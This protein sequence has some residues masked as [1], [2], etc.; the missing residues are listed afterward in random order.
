MKVE[1]IDHMGSDLSVVNAARV[2]FDKESLYYKDDVA[3][4]GDRPH[5]V[6]K[7]IDA[8]AKLIKYLAEH[9]HWSPFAHATVSMRWK[10]PIFVARQ[11]VKHQV[12]LSW[13]E[14]SRRY[15]KTEPELYWPE[16]WRRAAEN[17]KQG[18]SDVVLEEPKVS[19]V[20]LYCSASL[21]IGRKKYC[22][23]NHQAQHS[24]KKRPFSTKFT[25]WRATAKEQKIPFTIS[26]D[27]LD[28]PKTCPY[29]GIE[30]AYSS[31][32]K[33]DNTASLD[34]IKPEL[35]Y[36]PGNVQ[37]ISLLANR[38]KSDAN[39]E[40]LL[41]F[42]KSVLLLH[43]GIA[44]SE[45]N[46]V[47]TVA[48]KS[49]ELYNQLIAAGYCPEQARIVLPQAMETEWIWTGSLYAWAR[50]YNQR[51]DPHAQQETRQLVLTLDEIC[52]K[53]YPVSWKALTQS[54]ELQNA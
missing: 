49:I 2:S 14:V 27:D 23:D 51:T 26:E 40:Q 12:G 5:F 19:G 6:P 3:L 48:E 31:N 36:V 30:L 45:N 28:W 33:G 46:S 10:A 11:L 1:Y 32:D 44:V 47:K 37:I 9:G 4:V 7:L 17:V 22:C 34:K 18:S 29:L 43:G 8:D 13:N 16:K 21:P 53:L 15:V 54:K 50:V 20:C 24:A 39:F 52:G 35:G 42:A 41:S 38:M 25:R